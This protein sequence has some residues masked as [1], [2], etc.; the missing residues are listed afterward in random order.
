MAEISLRIKIHSRSVHGKRGILYEL[1]ENFGGNLHYSA[2]AASA[3]GTVS[4]KPLINIICSENMEELPKTKTALLTAST[5]KKLFGIDN[6]K[7]GGLTKSQTPC[8]RNV[9]TKS[10]ARIDHLIES[11]VLDHRSSPQLQLD[12]ESLVSLVHCHQHRRGYVKELRLDKWSDLLPSEPEQIPYGTS[13]QRKIE[14]CLGRLSTQCMGTTGVNERCKKSIGGQ[15]IQ[16]CIKTIEKISRADVYLNDASLDLF[17]RVL[18]TNMRC[19]LHTRQSCSKE[20]ALWNAR[21]RDVLEKNTPGSNKLKKINTSNKIPRQVLSL[22]VYEM[23][24]KQKDAISKS[25]PVKNLASFPVNADSSNN[26]DEYWPEQ[27]DTAPFDIVERS[28]RPNNYKASYAGVRKQMEKQLSAKDQ[29][30]GYLYMYEVDGNKG[31]VKIGFTTRP[32]EKRHGE[33][34][35]DCNRKS[36][37]LFPIPASKA[38]LVPNVPRVEKLCHAELKHRQVII[39]CQGCLKTHEEWFELSPTEGIAVVEK[40]SAWMKREPYHPDR[41]LLKEEEARK[42]AKM[43]NYMASLLNKKIVKQLHVV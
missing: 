35:F 32:I 9:P 26:L 34:C 16:N 28:D 42:A 6:W 8:R 39:Y 23:G 22:P 19:H 43:D 15:K 24:T 3:G 17:L 14:L 25:G 29:K 4:I 18:A 20:L 37:P 38:E 11:M 1:N 40:W 13:I 5:L 36:R 33:W 7:C 31:F 2:V 30:S 12:L 10:H 41:L 21:I 27:Y